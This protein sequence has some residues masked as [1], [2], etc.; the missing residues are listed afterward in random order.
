LACTCPAA[1]CRVASLQQ[2]KF[3]LIIKNYHPIPWHNSI[4]LPWTPISP[5]RDE[6]DSAR[7]R[8][9]VRMPML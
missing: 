8:R 7:P 3:F 9:Q 1:W 6:S 2:N 5:S 4:F